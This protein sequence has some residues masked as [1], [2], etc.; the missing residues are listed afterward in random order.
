MARN[1]EL[2]AR[3]RDLAA[4][5]EVCRRLGAE[6]QW[7]RRQVDTY[8]RVPDGRLK[9][10]E[11]Q[12]G[13]ATLVRYH[14]PD[15]AAARESQYELTPVDEP[16]TKLAELA[17]RHGVAARV[18]KTRTLYLLDTIRIHLDRVAGLGTFIEFEA[19]MGEGRGDAAT[20]A[21][22]RDL[23]GAFGIVD[24]DLVECSY[25]DMGTQKPR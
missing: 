2:K 23:R 11:E 25:A 4:A 9:L 7:V 10:R 13:G 18:E 21:R 8:F 15:Q 1:I 3:C 19:V 24:D 12:P 22:L 5:E 6:R 17:A 14:R 16:A 20:R